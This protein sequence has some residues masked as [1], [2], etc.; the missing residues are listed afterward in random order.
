MGRD[1]FGDLFSHIRMVYRKAKPQGT[2][3]KEFK[4]HVTPLS[5]P[6]VFVDEVLLP[7]SQAFEAIVDADYAS[8]KHAEQVND[9][10]RWLGR[11]EFKDWMPP[12]LA[13]YIR[14]DNQPDAMLAF[15]RVWSVWPIRCLPGA[16][17]STSALN[18]S[19][20]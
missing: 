18:A 13:F 7:M 15:F 16:A 17:G 5:N 3:L 12:A 8:Q 9:H 11:L 19:P 4:E 10:L 1:E 20:L 6:K 14:Y 2:L